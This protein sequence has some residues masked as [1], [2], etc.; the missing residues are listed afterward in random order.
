MSLLSLGSDSG[1][2]G[3]VRSARGLRLLRTLASEEELLRMCYV[4]R[5]RATDMVSFLLDMDRNVST[6][7]AR[8][9]SQRTGPAVEPVGAA[10]AG[11][12]GALGGADGAA[13]G[14][15]VHPYLFDT[16]FRAVPDHLF[17]NLR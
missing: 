7:D 13:A 11:E 9:P 15:A 14:S 5:G 17:G 1:G 3:V 8:Q 10:G 2:I 6:Q 4:R 12:D 16:A